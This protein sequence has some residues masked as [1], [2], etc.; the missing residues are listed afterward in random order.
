MPNVFNEETTGTHGILENLRVIKVNA[1][2]SEVFEIPSD[3][4]SYIIMNT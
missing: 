3:W 2:G 4:T 1:G